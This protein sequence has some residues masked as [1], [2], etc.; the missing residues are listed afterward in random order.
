MQDQATQLARAVSV[1][2]LAGTPVAGTPVHSN[3]I[4]AAQPAASVGRVA[5]QRGNRAKN[6]VAPARPRRPPAVSKADGWE[7]F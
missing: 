3:Q 7:E 4:A 1:F 5:V 2:K 6:A